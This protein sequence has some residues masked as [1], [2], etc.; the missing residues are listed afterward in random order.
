[1][2]GQEVLAEPTLGDDPEVSS[3]IAR[4]QRHCPG[5]PPN[6]EV[7]TVVEDGPENATWTVGADPPPTSV[8]QP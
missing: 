2:D 5:L 6:L 3:E 1:M 4:R 7:S 8:R